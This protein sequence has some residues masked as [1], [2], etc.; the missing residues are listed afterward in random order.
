MTKLIGTIKYLII[1]LL[2]ISQMAYGQQKEVNKVFEFTET[3][4]S[5]YLNETRTLIVHLPK[6]Y[7]E[8]KDVTYPVLY[9]LDGNYHHDNT[10]FIHNFLSGKKHIPEA[11]LVFIPNT[12]QRKRDYNTFFRDTEIVN[13][14]ANH[15]LSFIEKEAIPQI[16][17]KYKN[18]NYRMLSGHS[19]GGLFVIHS[20]IKR[21]D[22]FR[23]RFAFS[24]S[25][26]HI[27][28]QR[29]IL[30]EFLKDNQDLNGYFYM[31]VG[32]TEFY[33]QT[34]AF[35][36]VEQ[37]FEDYAPKG[38]RYDF[39]FHDVDG[40]QSSPFIGQH[41]AFKRLFAPLRL[42]QAA[43]EKMSYD[44][45][46]THF[47]NISYEFGYEIK[48]RESELISMGNYFVNYEPNLAVVDNLVALSKVYYPESNEI[49]GNFLFY[50]QWLSD[51]INSEFKYTPQLK[52]D[53]D[54]LNSMGYKHLLKNQFTEA[55]YL[56]KLATQLYPENSNPY[57]SYGEGL[58]QTGELK[59][60][61]E[62]YKK[63]HAI[64]SAQQE[65]AI[66]VYQKNIDRVKDKLKT[67]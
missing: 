44:D 6:S 35:A 26:H 40:H 5:T 16:E 32:G 43:Y 25:S 56:L 36:E 3:I 61:L 50:Q 24:P 31:N 17:K 11:I 28:K 30:K 47:D 9:V 39:D 4:E 33:K 49:E 1:Q 67:N 10:L 18:S 8:S 62:M 58:E 19:N 7:Y 42:N 12:G 34:D 60:A 65:E 59:T 20:L 54:V 53:E 15:F 14:G 55:L 27:P 13:E 64:A 23:A 41:M 21:P 29:E 2:L 48:P 66:V 45:V 38:L 22:L 57:D 37:I 51:G 46:I 52:P 63:A